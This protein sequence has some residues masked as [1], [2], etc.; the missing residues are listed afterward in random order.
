MGEKEKCTSRQNAYKAEIPKLKWRG[1]SVRSSES[2]MRRLL[3]NRN[4]EG[5]DKF[6]FQCHLRHKE[7]VGTLSENCL[8][9]MQT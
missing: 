4:S 2:A 1:R 5:T 3:K 6:S 9:E 7:E 8:A